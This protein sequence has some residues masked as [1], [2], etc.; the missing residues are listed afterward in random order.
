[1]DFLKKRQIETIATTVSLNSDAVEILS[2][3]CNKAGIKPDDLLLLCLKCWVHKSRNIEKS[4]RATVNYNLE[5]CSLIKKIY[6]TTEE[7][8]SLQAIR[9]TTKTS[10][11]Y[12]AVMLAC[13]PGNED[14]LL[15]TAFLME[16]YV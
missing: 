10:V 16:G 12:P 2:K 1:M 7:H 3:C 6:M 13:A 11:S 8:H 14:N 15:N 4:E 5:S 9:Y